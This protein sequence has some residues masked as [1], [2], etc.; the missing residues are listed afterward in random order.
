MNFSKKMKWLFVTTTHRLTL[1]LYQGSDYL[2]Q[3]DC[4][5]PESQAA[6]NIVGEQDFRDAFKGAKSL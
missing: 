6:L 2:K 1:P 3:C 5:P 4:R